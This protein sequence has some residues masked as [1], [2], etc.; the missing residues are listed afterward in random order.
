MF[1]YAIKSDLKSARSDET[2]NVAKK[3]YLAGLKSV[4]DKLHIDKLVNVPCGLNSSKRK[5]DSVDADKLKVFHIDFKNLSY[6]VEK[7]V[8]K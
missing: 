2:S 5:V 4:V 7:D 3:I 6:V 8:L 1:F